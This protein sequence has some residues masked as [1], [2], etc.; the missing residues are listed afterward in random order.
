MQGHGGDSS[1]E[2]TM[3]FA[4]ALPLRTRLHVGVKKPRTL[5][6]AAVL[7]APAL[8]LALGVGG[9]PN[10]VIGTE[11]SFAP[12]HFTD[13]PESLQN[14]IRFPPGTGDVTVTL[15]CE[16]PLSKRGHFSGIVC[17]APDDRFK[18]FERAL[19]W[20]SRSAR[21]AP[22]VLEGKPRL[23]HLQFRVRFLRRDGVERITAVANQA[24]QSQTFGGE[25][26]GPQRSVFDPPAYFGEIC[27]RNTH[28]WVLATVDEYGRTSAVTTS[29][30]VSSRACRARVVRRFQ[31]A[32]FVPAYV[33]G[34]PVR[35]LYRE[36]VA[37]APAV[38]P[39]VAADTSANSRES[40]ETSALP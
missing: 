36:L 3:E 29:S 15:T 21:I 4:A 1:D 35:A 32:R 2:M 27:S 19:A 25:Y 31:T 40:S 7:L 9:A 14:R 17:F 30:V 6:A 33:G 20:A 23:I 34:D 11:A 16:G 22:A 28:L 24:L 38:G 10:R 12:A 5:I 39:R 26:S 13:E 37:T 18:D 8:T